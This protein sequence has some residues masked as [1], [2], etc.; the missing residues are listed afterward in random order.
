MTKE[1]DDDQ[2]DSDEEDGGQRGGVPHW[3]KTL[4][5]KLSLALAIY[6]IFVMILCLGTNL[7]F[8]GGGGH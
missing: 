8:E 4:L 6:G 5:R 2:S 7:F 3:R 1:D